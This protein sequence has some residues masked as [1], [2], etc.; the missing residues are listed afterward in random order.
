MQTPQQIFS[1][2]K[3]YCNFPDPEAREED[4]YLSTDNY[5]ERIII[6]LRDST[7]LR[8]WTYESGAS[9]LVLI[10]KY[11][12]F[13]IKI[14]FMG[15]SDEEYRSTYTPRSSA[16]KKKSNSADF[17]SSDYHKVNSL[18]EYLNEFWNDSTPE[19]AYHWDYC[20]LEAYIYQQ[21]VEFG[22]EE[23]FARE[24]LLGCI[25]NYP[26]Y[27]QDKAVTFSDACESN[28]FHKSPEEI[29]EKI[30]DIEREVDEYSVINS[31]WCANAL[32]CYGSELYRQFLS[33]LAQFDISD[34]HDGNIGYIDDIPVLFD[35]SGFMG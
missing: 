13:V 7:D 23:C 1:I 14:P 15:T 5:I 20:A 21:A 9:K 8:D 32:E 26:I 12:P 22:V 10:F 19:K 24:E 25:N 35:Y 16:Y 6:P 4:D 3:R 33:F 31:D 17:T 29:Y 30:S 2:L 11:L 34:L 28:S 27:L 18:H